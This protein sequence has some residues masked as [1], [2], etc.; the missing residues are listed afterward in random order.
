MICHAGVVVAEGVLA[1]LL[2]VLCVCV[3]VWCV[4][5]RVCTCGLCSYMYNACACA[6]TCV[7][8]AVCFPFGEVV[9]Y[10]WIEG[11]YTGGLLIL[12]IV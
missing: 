11:I 9:K 3:C 1:V 5:L 2:C 4:V 12:Y 7:P 8:V 10:A 6:C